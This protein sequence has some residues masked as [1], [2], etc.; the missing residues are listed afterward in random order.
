MEGFPTTQLS[1][2]PQQASPEKTVESIQDAV[3]RSVFRLASAG[4][5]ASLSQEKTVSYY[6][7]LTN[8]NGSSWWKANQKTTFV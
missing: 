6:S 3:C 2:F 7:T 8:Q 4:P 1:Q 5:L